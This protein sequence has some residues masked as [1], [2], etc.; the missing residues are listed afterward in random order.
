V[1]GLPVRYEPP[2]NDPSELQVEL[3]P[4]SD[5][6][7]LVP[8]YLQKGTPRK[9]ANLMKIPVLDVSGEA[10]YHRVFDSCDAKWLN[11]AGVKT[12]YIKLEDAGLPG[13]GHEMMLEKNSDGIAA[14]FAGWLEK[15]VH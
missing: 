12:D 3:E 5:G 7:W 4:Q 9:L 2:I 6:P 15:N 10:S 11:Q 8:C 14:Y 1:T 13:N